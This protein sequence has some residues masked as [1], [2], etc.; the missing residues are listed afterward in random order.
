MTARGF[1]WPSLIFYAATA[2]AVV[3]TLCAVAAFMTGRRDLGSTLMAAFLACF[4]LV[5]F[6]VGARAVR[7]LNQVPDGGADPRELFVTNGRFWLWVVMKNVA[8]VIAL[9]AAVIILVHGPGHLV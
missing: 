1:N 5:K 7:E 9:A 6:A 8:A 2:V 4:S 3:V